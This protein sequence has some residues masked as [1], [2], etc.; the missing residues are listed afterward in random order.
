MEYYVEAGPRLPT[1]ADLKNHLRDEPLYFQ[2]LEDYL[3]NA[4]KLVEELRAKLE[5]SERHARE[6]E[7]V[8]V[9]RA[10]LISRA[11]PPPSREQ[12]EVFHEIMEQQ[13]QLEREEENRNQLMLLILEQEQQEYLE[14]IEDEDERPAIT[15][16]EQGVSW[17]EELMAERRQVP[18]VPFLNEENQD[19]VP[20]ARTP[21]PDHNDVEVREIVL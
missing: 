1:L 4:A 13:R 6:D 8:E 19:V 11:S 21:T 17:E 18:H 15:P 12:L 5:K 20:R 3:Q 10:D 14:D 2:V 7:A 9:A 16:T